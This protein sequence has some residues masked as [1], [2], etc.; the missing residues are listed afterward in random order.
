MTNRL[1]FSASY[2]SAIL[3]HYPS[4]T[5]KVL[6]Y[7]HATYYVVQIRPNGVVTYDTVLIPRSE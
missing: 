3:L 7:E 5:L 1:S 4:A 6:D 2:R